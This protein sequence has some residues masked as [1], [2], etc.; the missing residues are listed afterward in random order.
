VRIDLVTRVEGVD[1]AQCFA[2]RTVARLDDAEVNL[3][4][5]DDLRTNMRAMGQPKRFDDLEHLEQWQAG[6]CSSWGFSLH[7]DQLT[8]FSPLTREKCA[9]LFV[10]SV[11]LRPR[12]WAAMRISIDPMVCPEVSSSWRIR[13]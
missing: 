2:R 7:L 6:R 4:G 10:T 1:F 8:T 12:T 9:L 13:P 3:I 11:P 5:L